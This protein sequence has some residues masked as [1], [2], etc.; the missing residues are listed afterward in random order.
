MVDTNRDDRMIADYF[1]EET[2]KI[3]DN[4]L[5]ASSRSRR[6]AIDVPEY[7]RQL[8]EMLG[9][10]PLPERTDLKATIT[11]RT[12]HDDF[13]VEN[14]HFQSRPGL[15][16]TGNLYLPKEVKEPLPAILYVCGHANIKKGDVSF[17]AKAHYQHHGAGFARNGNLSLVIDTLQ[18]GEIEGIHH[19]TY[20]YGYWWWLNRGYTP[21]GVEAWNCM[22][23]LDYLQTRKEVDPQR[24]GVTVPLVAVRTVGGSRPSTIV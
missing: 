7:H 13:T 17:G 19:G 22:R 24:L 21:T 12:E 20:R 6:L 5:M 14:L 15:Y 3:R 18:L 23:A 2:A 4:C 11:S 1:R 16:V 8:M 9:L 10:D